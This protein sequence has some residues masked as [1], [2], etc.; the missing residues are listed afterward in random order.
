MTIVVLLPKSEE[1]KIPE[2]QKNSTFYYYFENDEDKTKNIS[3]I[4]NETGAY[5]IC[6]FGAKPIEGGK[7]GK[8]CG[9]RNFQEG[10]IIDFYFEGRKA[11]GKGG[12]SCGYYEGNGYN[13]AGLGLAIWRGH[14]EEFTII[15]GGGGDSEGQKAK[16]GDCE[17]D[18]EG[19]Y[20][21]KGAKNDNY[22]EKGDYDADNGRKYHGGKGGGNDGR[23]YYYCGGGGGNGYYGGGGGGRY[24]KE[25]VGGGGGGSNFCIEDKTTCIKG[26]ENKGVYSGGS[27]NKSK[28]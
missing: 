12:E 22:G 4:I 25:R 1:N 6:V 7:G 28:N 20:G 11:G 2:E 27:I 5:T 16:G 3:T 21:G 14:E 19:K 10:D 23:W 26:D 18:G 8:Q 13:G 17:K 15:A 24:Y 9:V